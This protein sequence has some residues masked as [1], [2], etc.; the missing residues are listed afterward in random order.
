MAN[1]IWLDETVV[2]NV[3]AVEVTWLKNGKE[4]EGL[5]VLDEAEFDVPDATA[6]NAETWFKIGEEDAI[7]AIA[8]V[9]VL[10]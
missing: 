9:E 10:E 5:R 7:A 3:K 4:L 2:L 1:E 8:S 6:V